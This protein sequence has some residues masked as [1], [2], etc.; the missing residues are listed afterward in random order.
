MLAEGLCLIDTVR[1]KQTLC[2]FVLGYRGSAATLLQE[3][4]L[5][6]VD[7]AACER[8][9]ANESNRVN[10]QYHIC[11]GFAEGGKDTCQGELRYISGKN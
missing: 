5:P 6:I 9:Y 7:A 11:A 8:A 3:V 2:S 4:G 1:M 10:P